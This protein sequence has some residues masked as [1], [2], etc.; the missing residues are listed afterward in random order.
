VSW[1]EERLGKDA[2]GAML[3]KAATRAMQREASGFTSDGSSEVET[4]QDE[5]RCIP[6][7]ALREKPWAQVR[8]V[9]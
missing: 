9:Q 6:V 2:A 1:A 5:A 3:Q 7:T 8:S 4:I